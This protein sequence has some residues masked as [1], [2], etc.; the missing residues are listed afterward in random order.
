MRILIGMACIAI[1][2]FFLIRK[3]LKDKRKENIQW[4]LGIDCCCFYSPPLKISNN[5]ITIIGFQEVIDGRSAVRY[6]VVKMNW[7]GKRTVFG[8][9]FIYGDYRNPK[10]F[11]LTVTNIPNGEHY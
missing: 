10:C 5:G 7:R 6:S 9:G 8:Q 3:M 4:G 11:H 1:F 2:I